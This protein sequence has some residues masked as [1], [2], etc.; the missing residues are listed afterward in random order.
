VFET[1]VPGTPG[2]INNRGSR[3]YQLW[4]PTI[5]SC[6][7]TS[8]PTPW[9]PYSGDVDVDIYYFYR[10]FHA[11][12]DNIVKAILDELQVAS[13]YRNDKQIRRLQVTRVDMDGTFDMT[14]ITPQLVRQ[15]ASGTD[16]ILIRVDEP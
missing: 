5:A 1:I 2:S 7:A 8:L 4:R 9:T 11:D 16:F 3:R 10:G 13:V 12:V 6:A 14:H 15:I